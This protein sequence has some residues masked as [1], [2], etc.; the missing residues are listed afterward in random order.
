MMRFIPF[1]PPPLPRRHELK[2]C[3]KTIII[4]VP[5]RCTVKERERRREEGRRTKETS[6]EKINDQILNIY[7]T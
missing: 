7:N 5:L 1:P 2:T 3:L 6:R 4:I